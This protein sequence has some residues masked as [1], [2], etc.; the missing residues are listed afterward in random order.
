MTLVTAQMSVSLD[1]YYAG[2]KQADDDASDLQSWMT[3]PEAAGF[4]RVTRWAIDAEAWR[5][6][7]GFSGGAR[8]VNSTSSA[9]RTTQSAR[10]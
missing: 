9:R 5:Q 3:G 10:T 4:F 6:R 1:G 8:N 2:P 7:L